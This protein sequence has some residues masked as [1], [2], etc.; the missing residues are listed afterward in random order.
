MKTT[1]KAKEAVEKARRELAEIDG[2]ADVLAA[3][4]Q[5]ELTR[6]AA[7]TLAGVTAERE[8]GRLREQATRKRDEVRARR[9]TLQLALPELIA[10]LEAAEEA[11]RASTASKRR[12]ELRHAVANRERALRHFAARTREVN[13]AAAEVGRHRELVNVCVETLKPLL[14]DNEGLGLDLDEATWPEHTDELVAVLQAGPRRPRAERER[15]RE[16][17]AAV[18]E[19]QAAEQ[20]DWLRRHP[21]EINLKL[22]P[23]HLQARGREVLDAHHVEWEAAQARQRQAAEGREAAR[24]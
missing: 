18:A 1:Q 19:R 8:G 6:I 23:A 16:Q 17:A 2:T 13:A 4:T 20:L 22:L 3:E 14:R 5:A 24:V 9:E 7:D 10:R 21:S 11:E 12:D 15:K